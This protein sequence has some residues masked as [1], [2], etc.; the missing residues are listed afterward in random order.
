M[1]NR[2]GWLWLDAART[3]NRGLLPD[4]YQPCGDE[5]LSVTPPRAQAS[6]VPEPWDLVAFRCRAGVGL[7]RG[8]GEGV[9]WSL[10]VL[11]CG[12]VEFALP[13]P[14]GGPA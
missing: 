2:H 10:W 14:P 5:R 8:E 3:V 4:W 7:G 11:T 1:L 12:A 13:A 9:G 6:A